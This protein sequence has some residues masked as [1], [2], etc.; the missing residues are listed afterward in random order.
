MV[1][2]FI[3]EISMLFSVFIKKMKN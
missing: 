3:F 2:Y 1:K